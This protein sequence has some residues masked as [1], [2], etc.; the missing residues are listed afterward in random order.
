MEED[1][2]NNNHIWWRRKQR[3]LSYMQENFRDMQELFS[4]V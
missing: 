3:Y 2:Y 4:P 1:I